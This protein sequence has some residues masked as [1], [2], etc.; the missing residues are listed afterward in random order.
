MKITRHHCYGDTSSAAF[1][2]PRHD[3]LILYHYSDSDDAYVT[4][5]LPRFSSKEHSLRYFLHTM[6]MPPA[7]PDI[8]MPPPDESAVIFFAVARKE[9]CRHDICLSRVEARSY[10]K[11]FFLLSGHFFD[12]LR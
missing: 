6:P 2:I 1:I 7:L 8:F 4:C 11:R 12:A 10:R 3:T 5:R 9:C